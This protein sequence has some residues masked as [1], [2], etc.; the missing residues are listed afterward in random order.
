[1]GYTNTG[2]V[3]NT[4]YWYR[5]RARNG[6]A[7]SEY[8]NKFTV[9][10]PASIVYVNFNTTIANAAFPWNNLQTSPMSEFV[11]SDLRDQSGAAAG[12]TIRLVKIFNGEFTAG[13]NTGSNAGVV[14][15]NV[16]MS[17]YWLD[18]T[19]QCQFK[20]SGLNHSRRYSIGFVGSSSTAGWFKGNYTATYTINGRTVYLN[21]WMNS[22]KIVYISDVVPNAGGEVFLDFSTTAIAQWGF[23]AG[24][25]I[26]EY[27]D[28]QGGSILYMS[29]S[30]LADI[31]D[32]TVLNNTLKVEAYPNPFADRVQVVFEHDGAS[33]VT[34]EIVDMYGRTV[35]R[36]EFRDLSSGRRV[37]QLTVPGS[38]P[39]TG[40]FMITLKADGKVLKTIKMLR[41]KN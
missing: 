15:D 13:V 16:L 20:L 2:L 26:Q 34:A 22:T 23:N 4:K 32:S 37:L 12:I 30:E 38:A 5:V 7:F 6:G 31:T 8:S 18:N 41:N 29:N 11:V 28:Q 35:H 39:K 9:V 33:D 21:S 27:N 19:Q 40:M 17:N 10:T 1:T 25:I 14:P 24:I 3:P 36:Q